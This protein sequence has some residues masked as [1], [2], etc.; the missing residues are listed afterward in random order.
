M[1]YPLSLEQQPK[2]AQKQTQRLM[3]TPQM[4]QAIHLLQLPILELAQAVDQEI[5]QNPVLEYMEDEEGPAEEVREETPIE[6]KE[7]T[8]EEHQLDV[9]KQLDEEF[10]DCTAG[11]DQFVPRRS[12]E[13]DKKKAFLESSIEERISLQDHLMSQAREAFS[14]SKEL[15]AAEVI[16][17]Y[18]DENGFMPTPLNEI[19]ASFSLSLEKLQKVL[20]VIKTF[21]PVG[22]ASQDV[23][24]MLLSQLRHQGKENSL[25]YRMVQDFFEHLLHNRLPH[26]QKEMKVSQSEI[27]KVIEKEIAPLNLHPGNSFSD[28]EAATLIPDVRLRSEGEE[29]VAEVNEDQLQPLRFNRKYLKLLDDPATTRETK[30]FIK[31]KLLSAKWLVRNLHQRGETLY[32]IAGFLCEKQRQFF[33]DPK[34]KLAPL[35]MQTVAEELGLHESTIA[36]AVANKYIETPRGIFPFRH[37]FSSGYVD[38]EGQEVSSK[39]VCDL[40]QQL[41]G[42]E[43]KRKPL[44]D[45]T[46]SKK[47]HSMGVTCARRTVA[48]YRSE[49]NIGNTQQ[50]RKY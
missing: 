11:S 47:I 10:R 28:V 29:Y 34:G 38:K 46:L 31:T 27:Q 49:L 17:G 32:K 14:D 21:D 50:R 6:E 1:S 26:I 43:D 15:E 40:I 48:K 42:E 25:A 22:I 19:A 7:L 18:L 16:I 23:Q 20:S 3:M 39:T 9:L 12:A 30:D 8:F 45:E 2:Q 5:E 4:Q 13:E 24:E 33:E 37:F 44:S 41:I 36:R 35:T